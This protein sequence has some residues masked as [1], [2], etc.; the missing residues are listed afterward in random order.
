MVSDVRMEAQQFLNCPNP[1]L[2]KAW[3]ILE[4]EPFKNGWSCGIK[5]YPMKVALKC[6]T[7]LPELMNIYWAVLKRYIDPLYLKLAMPLDRF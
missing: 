2:S 3:L 5:N 1:L 4:P 7:F 6:I